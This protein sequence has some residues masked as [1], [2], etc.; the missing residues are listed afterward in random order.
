MTDETPDRIISGLPSRHSKGAEPT[1]GGDLRRLRKKNREQ[2][3][4]VA[5][6]G[7]TVD[8]QSHVSVTGTRATNA[9]VP[10][11][12]SEPQEDPTAR[13]TI[14]FRKPN[15][16]RARRAFR[17][18]QHLEGDRSW[19]DFVDKAVAAETIRRESAHNQGQAFRG[20]DGPLAAGRPL[21]S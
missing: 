17:A 3:P 16:A 4:P 1:A 12:P 8:Q 20:P 2:Q 18:T 6:T 21:E 19:S 5:A 9:A 11:E 14:Y 15:L 13:S 7:A 10:V